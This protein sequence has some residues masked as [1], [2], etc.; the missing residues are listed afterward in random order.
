MTDSHTI[1]PGEE[2]EEQ[3]RIVPV[4]TEQPADLPNAVISFDDAAGFA[5]AQRVASVFAKS[6]LV[7]TQYRNN[8]ANCLVALNMANRMAADPLMVMQNLY[9]VRGRPGWSS[10]FLISCFNQCGRFTAMRFE[11]HG[12]EGQPDWGCRA[13]ALE[14]RTNERLDGTWITWTMVQAE[15]WNKKDGSK[16]LTMPQQMFMYRAASFFTRAYAPELT[17]GLHTREELLDIPPEGLPPEPEWKTP[18]LERQRP[19][20]VQTKAPEAR[21]R[22]R[23]TPKAVSS[24]PDVEPTDDDLSAEEP[25]PADEASEESTP[26]PEPNKAPPPKDGAAHDI[27]PDTIAIV[28]KI[29]ALLANTT[30]GSLER[31]VAQR[32]RTEGGVKRLRDLPVSAEVNEKVGMEISLSALLRELEDFARMDEQGGGDA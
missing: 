18:Q 8:L 9:L 17:M 25:P 31:T 29:S 30:D 27:P 2:P 19:Q 32:Y 23:P 10:Q 5:L 4:K 15:G 16:W 24:D 26:E 12:K 11:W 14:K 13:Y 21:P 1:V 7:P 6:E 22:P 28:S 3:S 20:P